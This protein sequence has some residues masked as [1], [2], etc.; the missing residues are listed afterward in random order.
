MAF[1]GH[2]LFKATASEINGRV[3]KT[4]PDSAIKRQMPESKS[5]FMDAQHAI[6]DWAPDSNPGH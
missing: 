2:G 1:P 3:K 4:A 5:Q 6:T